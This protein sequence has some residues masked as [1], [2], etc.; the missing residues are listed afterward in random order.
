[1]NHGTILYKQTNICKQ[2]CNVLSVTYSMQSSASGHL[3]T[4]DE[5]FLKLL[6]TKGN[7]SPF[8]NSGVRKTF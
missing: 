2:Y 3:I 4:G 7:I 1:M 8:G 6:I 5:K